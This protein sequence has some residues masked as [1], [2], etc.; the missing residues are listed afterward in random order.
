[1]LVSRYT[2]YQLR[3][4]NTNVMAAKR[5]VAV[6]TTVS[7][8]MT[9]LLGQC[10]FSRLIHCRKFLEDPTK[11]YRDWREQYVSLL[12]RS[13]IQSLADCRKLLDICYLFQLLTGVFNFP[14]A[15]LMPRN[16]DSRLRNFHPQLLCLPF[17]RTTA[18][19]N[20]FFLG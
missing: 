10:F 19:M 9:P 13:G 20:S 17:A 11:S 2:K 15:P 14:D 5:L 1:M 4:G 8:K 12:E 7:R 18:Y 3:Q 16:L 6:Q